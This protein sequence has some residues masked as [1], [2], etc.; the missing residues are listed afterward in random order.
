MAGKELVLALGVIDDLDTTYFNGKQ[1]GAT[2]MDVENFWATERKYKVPADIVKAGEVVI[3][4]RVVDRWY[5]AGFMSEANAMTLRTVDDKQ[6]VA[7]AGKWLY[8]VGPNRTQPDPYPRRPREPLGPNSPRL[9]SVLYNGMINPLVP[10]GMKGAIWYQGES[11]ASRAYEYRTLFPTMIKSWREAWGQGDFPFLFVQ[12]ANFMAVQEEPAQESTWAELREAQSM[13]LS[14]PNTG[15]ASA[16]DIGQA[17]N[18]HPRNKQD[19]GKRLMLAALKVAYNKEL[20]YTGPTYKGMEVEDGQIVLTFA[21]VGSGMMPSAGEE[22]KGFAIAGVDREF[23]WA[24]AVIE[25]NKIVV[26]SDEVAEPVAVRYGWA[27]NPIG[28]LYNKEGLPANPFRTD[29]WPG[30]TWPKETRGE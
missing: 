22:L 15:M 3:A 9:P 26:S 30:V 7:L 2:G 10:F 25:G 6:T 13:T 24:D 21:G 14:L 19:V 5:D 28:N 27:N 1:V 17:D 12:L 11:N 8:K 29:D 20:V 18:I 4:V 16:I 23:V